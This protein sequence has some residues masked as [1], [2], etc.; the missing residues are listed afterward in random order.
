MVNLI[1]KRKWRFRMR[2]ACKY[3]ECTWCVY[4]N[5]RNPMNEHTPLVEIKSSTCLLPLVPSVFF[6]ESPLDNS[7]PPYDRS[8]YEFF[9]LINC[10]N[11]TSAELKPG[12]KCNAEVMVQ[13]N[14][15]YPLIREI[16]KIRGSKLFWTPKF[17]YF[18]ERGRL[19]G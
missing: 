6:F 19:I 7:C 3:I 8:C 11:L 2:I 9:Y 4:L 17:Q 18:R 5:R 12:L 14:W 1:D 13:E 10:L 16:P 15:T